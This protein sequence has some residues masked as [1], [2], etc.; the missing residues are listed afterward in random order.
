M[1]MNYIYY[2]QQIAQFM[3]DKAS[4]PEARHAHQGMADAYR[5]RMDDARTVALPAS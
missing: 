1:D 3:A 2:R 4:C 5:L